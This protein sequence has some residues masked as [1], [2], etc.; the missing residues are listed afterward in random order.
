MTSCLVAL[1]YLIDSDLSDAQR[2]VVTSQSIA[3]EFMTMLCK[4]AMLADSA[5][6]QQIV[7]PTYCNTD[8][9][10]DIVSQIDNV[11]SGFNQGRVPIEVSVDTR[12]PRVI[13]TDKSKLFFI[14]KSC[15]II[16]PLI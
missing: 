11:M 7:L 8:I 16:L 2:E 5:E 9:R 4:K 12:V 1:E 3:L 15:S 14:S 10:L 6:K 13:V